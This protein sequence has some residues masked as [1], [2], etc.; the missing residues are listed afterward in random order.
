MKTN[1]FNAVLAATLTAVMLIPSVVVADVKLSGLFSDN[2]VLQRGKETKVW[3]LADT[4]EK[5]T[6]EFNK[7]KVQAVA[8]DGKWI[9][10]LKNLQ[11]GGPY[12]M[13]IKGKNK[14][15]LSN[16]LVG[17]VWVCS[18][19]SNMAMTVKSCID[20]D[21]EIVNSTNARLRLY[22]VPRLDS[23]TAIEILNSTWTECNPKTISYFSAAGYFFGS[24]LVDTQN[25]PI[26]LINSSVGGTPVESWT[27]KEELESNP[28]LVDSNKWVVDTEANIKKATEKEEEAIAK[29]KADGTAE[30]KRTNRVW[31]T[32][33]GLYNGMIAPLLNYTIKGAIWYQGEANA[34]RAAAYG[35]CFPAMINSWRKNWNIPEFPFLFVQ[36]SYFG[37]PNKPDKGQWPLLRE[38][39]VQT[40]QTVPNTGMAICIDV[41]DVG[42]HPPNKRPVGERLALLAEHLEK[43]NN[44]LIY[45]GPI[46]DSVK[47]EN[48]K[49]YVKFK[50]IGDGIKTTKPGQSPAWFCIA[51]ED[52]VFYNAEAEIMDKDTVVVSAKDVP[53]PVAVRYAWAIAPVNNIVNSANLPA[54]PFRTDNWEGIQVP[55]PLLWE[56]MPEVIEM[57]INKTVNANIVCDGKLDEPVWTTNKGVVT[58]FYALDGAILTMQTTGYVVVDSSNVYI[59]ILCGGQGV[60]DLVA[61]K[62]D[63]DSSVFQDDAIEIFFDPTDQ[64]SNYYHVVLN[65]KNV[66][67][68]QKCTSEGAGKDPAWNGEYVTATFAGNDYW[69]TEIV[70]PI[71]KFPTV[72]SF[73][74]N[75]CRHVALGNINISW[76]K[77]KQ[78]FHNPANFVRVSVK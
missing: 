54:S 78:T 65:S 42:I 37:K 67:F 32:Q 51:G 4:G 44:S 35:K 5:V 10:L 62:T 43:K 25:I 48:G 73:A 29:A 18:G 55:I 64:R 76:A 50:Y 47:Y 22:T 17:D 34:P 75:L 68:D 2:M 16:I 66:R 20:A 41:G 39:Q 6:V 77:I 60:K 72:Q 19:Q 21:K 61:A 31:R 45:S 57:K 7:Q 59:G 8:K 40:W 14:I 11:P 15:E 36:L 28:E 13:I 70:F 56:G 3:G 71:N 23:T 69:S 1:L 46:Y 12:K 53:N 26:G 33:S 58:D 9:A 30:P 52:K 74:L 49:A 24:K 27:P 38:T 63:T